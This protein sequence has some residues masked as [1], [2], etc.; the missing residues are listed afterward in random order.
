MAADDLS[1]A[2]KALADPTRRQI[3]DTLRDGPRTTGDICARFPGMTR[4]AVMKHLS[5]L[6]GAR[7]V[8][9]RRRGRERWNHL[10]AV[11]LQLI[12]DR[13]LTPYQVHWASGLLRLK[14]VAERTTRKESCMSATDTVG[15]IRSMHITQEITI[16]APRSQVFAALLGDIGGWWGPP[17]TASAER[18][19][20]I[21]IEPQVGGR[22]F[23]DWGN[24]H[25]YLWAVVR[26]IN[27]DTTLEL[28]GTMGMD[29]AVNGWIC[30]ELADGPGGA[31]VL[32]LTHEAV[33][34]QPAEAEA[35]YTEGW[36][37]ILGTRFKNFVE[38][39][40]VSGLKSI[41][42]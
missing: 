41:R 35:G 28:S 26:G 23:E 27:P 31:T 22:F 8:L 6:E 25:G 40:E 20:R 10:N 9:P 19:Q 12:H 36:S 33:G 2:W 11:P 5:V 30:F 21:V 7:L 39:G 13:W 3:L 24:G 14:G 18:A 32:T 17:H 1:S 38:R 15:T 4:F 16:Q 34:T 37:E 29:G 42:A